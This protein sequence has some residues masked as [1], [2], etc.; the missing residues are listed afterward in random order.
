MIHA[1]NISRQGEKS[2]SV[3]VGFWNPPLLSTEIK[4]EVSLSGL[5]FMECFFSHSQLLLTTSTY[6]SFL[7]SWCSCECP[8]RG[9]GH[10]AENAVLVAGTPTRPLLFPD[11]QLRRNGGPQLGSEPSCQSRQRSEAHHPADEQVSHFGTEQS[12]TP[13]GI[14]P[15][16]RAEDYGTPSS[17]TFY[18]GKV[19][20]DAQ[21]KEVIL[22][23]HSSCV[24]CAKEQHHNP[25]IFQKVALAMGVGPKQASGVIELPQ[26]N[27][28]PQT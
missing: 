26:G 13:A 18:Q 3:H 15:L 22:R 6:L 12:S 5:K 21:P 23:K 24:L 20:Q 28:N 19:D 8:Q 10:C 4:T 16:L 25:L 1:S 17:H 7:S 14:L 2:P 11:T 27:C 9:P